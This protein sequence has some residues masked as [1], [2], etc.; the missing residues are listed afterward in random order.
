MTGLKVVGIGKSLEAYCDDINVTTDNLADFDIV[1][2]IIGK[3]EKVSGAILSRN[4]KCKVIGFGNWAAK[5][6]WPL[7]WVKPVKSEKIFGIFISDSYNE[8]FELNWNYRLQKFSN[9]IYSWSNRILDTLQQRVEVIRMFGL[10]R[11]YYVAA[12]LPIKPRMV[13]KFES[14]MGRYLWNFS[15]K[16]LRVAIDK[17]K[18]RKLEGG[19]NLPC[20]ASMADSLLFSQLCRLLRSGDKKTLG[21]VS[22]WL[23]DLLESL[24][25]D[26]GQLQLRARVAEPPEYFAYVADLV[27]EMV[28]SEKVDAGTIKTLTNKTVYAEMT[29]SFPPPK[30]VMDNSDRDYGTAWRRLHSP[31]VDDKARDVL[32]LLLHNKLPVKERLFRIGREHDPYCL[33][34]AGAEIH[35][36]VHSFCSCVSVCNTWSW[37]KRQVVRLGQMDMTVEDEDFVN[38]CFANSSC[39]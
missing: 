4:K 16:I 39:E 14:L 23:G 34:C 35:D 7:D 36:I 8:I 29:S 27:A 6:D 33:R 28:I 10:S 25:P 1:D 32:F 13:K 24:A 9:M 38:L 15:G 22:Y 19:L 20:L 5:E 2:K 3:F 17:M 21:H 30:V 31:V 37:L 18:N 12:V 11:V 26:L